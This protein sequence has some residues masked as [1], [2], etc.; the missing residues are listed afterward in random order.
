MLS[1]RKLRALQAGRTVWNRHQKD[2]DQAAGCIGKLDGVKAHVDD[3]E[4]ARGAEAG[5][6]EG[7]ALTKGADT[8]A[9]KEINAHVEDAGLQAL[10]SWGTH[11]ARASGLARPARFSAAPKRRHGDRRA[12]RHTAQHTDHFDFDSSDRG[13]SSSGSFPM[14]AA[15]F[16][17]SEVTAEGPSKSAAARCGRYGPLR[18][19]RERCGFLP[20]WC[21]ARY[22]ARLAQAHFAAP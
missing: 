16:D 5:G 19:N 21:C 20:R 2:W 1:L 3:Y 12:S 17:A 18:F 8:P 22:G 9:S 15:Q 6:Y 10:H 7:H 13:P 4:A 11:R 14:F